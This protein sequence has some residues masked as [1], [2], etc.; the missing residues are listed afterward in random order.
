MQQECVSVLQRNTKMQ[1]VEVSVD[2]QWTLV[3]PCVFTFVKTHGYAQHKTQPY[4]QSL[5]AEAQVGAL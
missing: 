4:L 3:D 1:H 2:A 5:K